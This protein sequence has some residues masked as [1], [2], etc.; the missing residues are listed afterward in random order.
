[1][2]TIAVAK[3]VLD[4]LVQRVLQ[5]SAPVRILLFGSAARGTFDG[6][7]DLDILVVVPDGEHRGRTCEAIHRNLFGFP[8][9]ADVVVA[10]ESDVE[11]YADS[12]YLVIGPALDEGVEL[13]RRDG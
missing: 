3:S 2:N 5:V 11:I 12:P 6:N 1:M 8:E 13:Y 9:P 7:S 10:T 4:D